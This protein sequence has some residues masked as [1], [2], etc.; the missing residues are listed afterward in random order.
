MRDGVGARDPDGVGQ[1]VGGVGLD[2]KVRR[3]A[4][5]KGGIRGQD[6][7]APEAVR[8]SAWPRAFRAA[9]SMEGTLIRVKKRDGARI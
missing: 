9:G 1:F 3:T 7:V 2:E 8:A 6:D 5:F 4:Y